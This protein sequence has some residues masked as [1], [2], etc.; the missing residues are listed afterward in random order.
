MGKQGEFAKRSCFVSVERKSQGDA[1]RFANMRLEP[2]YWKSTA[3]IA[4]EAVIM[5][6]GKQFSYANIHYDLQL[7]LRAQGG[8]ALQNSL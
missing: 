5:P 4:H 2:L 3:V 6:Q 7:C 8:K 1:E